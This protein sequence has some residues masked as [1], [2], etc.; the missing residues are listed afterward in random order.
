MPANPPK[1]NGN[2]QITDDY[3]TD[4]ARLLDEIRDQLAGISSQIGQLTDMAS[5]AERA[6]G[7]FLPAARKFLSG[8]RARLADRW[9]GN[10]Q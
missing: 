6:A 3:V 10:S 7:E 2:R 9:A 8:R 5:R 1:T 4:E